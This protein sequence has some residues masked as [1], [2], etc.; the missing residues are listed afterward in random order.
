MSEAGVSQPTCNRRNRRASRHLCGG[1]RDL[2]AKKTLGHRAER[3]AV[4]RE[5]AAGG[6]VVGVGR[7]VTGHH[8]S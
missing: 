2:T 4:R 1:A 6:E 3:R 7:R 5:L 8:V